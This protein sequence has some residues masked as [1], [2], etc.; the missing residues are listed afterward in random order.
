MYYRTRHNYHQHFTDARC[1]CAEYVCPILHIHDYFVMKISGY[2]IIADAYL[3]KME[4]IILQKG[5]I[6]VERPESNTSKVPHVSTFP[7]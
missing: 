5:N 1:K 3:V 4:L 7:S 2:T 6:L